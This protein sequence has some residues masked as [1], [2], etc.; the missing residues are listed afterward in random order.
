VTAR[1][2]H[3]VRHGEVDNPHGLI[4]GRLPGFGLTPRG[5]EQ[6]ARTAEHLVACS[7]DP[8]LFS[9]PLDRARETAAIIAERLRLDVAFEERVSEAQ[10][11]LDG[12]PRK[13][14]P[15]SAVRRILSQEARRLSERPSVIV[16]RMRAAIDDML[17]AAP[18][19]VIVVAHQFPI[20]MARV[21]LER[22][23]DFFAERVPWLY[24][25]GRC[26]YA[27]VTTLTLDTALRVVNAAYFSPR[28]F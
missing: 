7:D 16:T 27:S 22:R 13:G 1:R 8:R 14:W 15:R 2:V 25:R 26:E 28:I 23:G 24:L 5:R 6:A 17:R 19:D 12:A 18:R 11:G 4:Y 21:A 9:S 3:L 10:T 20:W